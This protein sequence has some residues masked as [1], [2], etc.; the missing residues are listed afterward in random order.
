MFGSNQE[1]LRSLA[2]CAVEQQTEEGVTES[3]A[4]IENKPGG[5]LER[6]WTRCARSE[7]AQREGPGR[8]IWRRRYPIADGGDA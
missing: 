3:T 2:A 6:Y 7:K 4:H 5:T 1:Q 8:C